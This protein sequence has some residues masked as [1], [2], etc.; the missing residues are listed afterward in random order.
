MTWDLSPSS[1]RGLWLS[2]ELPPEGGLSWWLRSRA[3]GER[4][5]WLRAL[6]SFRNCPN[7]GSSRVDPGGGVRSKGPQ[8]RHGGRVL[9]LSPVLN[10]GSWEQGRLESLSGQGTVRGSEPGPW[11]RGWGDT[12]PHSA[13]S[14]REGSL[15]APPTGLPCSRTRGRTRV[16]SQRAASRTPSR[17]R[18]HLVALTADVPA[19][20]PPQ[21]CPHAGTTWAALRLRPAHSARSPALAGLAPSTGDEAPGG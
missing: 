10:R 2:G 5:G 4:P 7:D 13:A 14:R 15:R 16:P 1:L 20:T 12:Q 3:A 19:D 9:S 6:T 17:L 11:S 21:L 18:P 8:G